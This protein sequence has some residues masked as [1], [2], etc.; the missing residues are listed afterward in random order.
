MS[1]DVKEVQDVLAALGSE[2]AATKYTS[3]KQSI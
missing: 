3:S 1:R 2:I